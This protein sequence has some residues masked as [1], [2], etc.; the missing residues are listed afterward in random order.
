MVF[1]SIAALL[2]APGQANYAAANAAVDCLAAGQQTAGTPVLS[3]Q[4]SAWASAGM[5]ANVR[6]S[7]M[8]SHPMAAVTSQGH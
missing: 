1:S 6:T 8:L 7:A 4:W 3:V 5:A 2:G